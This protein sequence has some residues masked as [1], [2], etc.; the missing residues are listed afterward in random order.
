MLG[1]GKGMV[2]TDSASASDSAEA[3][4]RVHG[5]AIRHALE[6]FA[7]RFFQRMAAFAEG[8]LVFEAIPALRFSR[9]LKG[10]LSY[11]EEGLLSRPY[12]GERSRRTGQSHQLHGRMSA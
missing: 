9:L 3:L 12:G 5:E 8:S 6:V 1:G 7:G 11:F 10:M 2:V 4:L